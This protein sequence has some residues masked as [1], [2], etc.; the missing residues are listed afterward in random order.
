[1]NEE[2]PRKVDPLRQVVATSACTGDFLKLAKFSGKVCYY[3]NFKF[4]FGF[5]FYWRLSQACQVL[6]CLFSY[7][8]LSLFDFGFNLFW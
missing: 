8:N 1:M 3:F 4:D 6:R 5:K 2:I 7:F